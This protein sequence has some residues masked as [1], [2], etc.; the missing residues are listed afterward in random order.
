MPIFADLGNGAEGRGV[1]SGHAELPLLWGTPVWQL[2][3]LSAGIE[4]EPEHTGWGI[5]CLTLQIWGTGL[6]G[7]ARAVAMLNRHFDEDPLFDNS[8]ITLQ[9]HHL[10]WEMDMPV[11]IPHFWSCSSFPMS[12]MPLLLS[13]P[14]MWCHIAKDIAVFAP[15]SSAAS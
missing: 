14:L 4:Q 11:S 3:H 13:C 10:G 2:L 12:L 6:K 1:R 15:A 7:G 5:S 9:W 8:S